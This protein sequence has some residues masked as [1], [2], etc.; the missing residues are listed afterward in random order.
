MD[1]GYI[2]GSLGTLLGTAGGVGWLVNLRAT[3]RTA[4]Y[5]ADKRLIDNYEQRLESLHQI[6]E[7]HNR[8]EKE[9]TQRIVALDKSLN[10]K[11]DLIRSLNAKIWDSEQETNR[12][13]ERLVEDQKKIADLRVSFER[14]KAWHCR[15]SDCPNR[16]PP[17]P[18]LRGQSFE[19]ERTANS[20]Q[21]T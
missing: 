21:G 12:L 19:E 9:L 15:N 7:M 13:N 18:A 20:E 6:V 4:K 17:N 2:I 10:G 8:N 11:T 1:I 5:D 3:R 14:Y 16:R